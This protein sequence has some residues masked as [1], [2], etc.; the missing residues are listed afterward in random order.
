MLILLGS[1]TEAYSPHVENNYFKLS[2]I[3]R[4]YHPN[5][6]NSVKAALSSQ[7]ILFE[8]PLHANSATDTVCFYFA[9][10]FYSTLESFLQGCIQAVIS[11]DFPATTK[12]LV[13][14]LG[15]P[16]IKMFHISLEGVITWKERYNYL[17]T[18][19]PQNCVIFFPV[20][21]KSE[22]HRQHLKTIYLKYPN[23]TLMSYTVSQYMLWSIKGDKMFQS[24]LNNSCLS[25]F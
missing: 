21:S 3:F 18:Q 8:S 9:V 5:G 4:K 10:H 13:S 1:K 17:Q 22:I 11:L 12:I 15:G 19:K 23:A 20:E 7:R 16:Y 6:G 14:A 24:A 25:W 2:W